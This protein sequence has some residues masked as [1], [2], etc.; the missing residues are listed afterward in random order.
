MRSNRLWVAVV[1][2]ISLLFAGSASAVSVCGKA[3]VPPWSYWKRDANGKKTKE[4][5]GA[6]V[7]TLKA[8]FARLG[9]A[10]EFR[11]E[12]SLARCLRMVESGD[13][14]FAMDAP[15]ESEGTKK[16]AY[17]MRYTTLTPQIFFR[18]DKPVNVRVIADLKNAK[19][20]GLA[21]A[22]YSNYGLKTKDLESATSLDELF[23]KVKE[24]ECDYFV[25]ELEVIAG[26]RI[27]G[28]D[29]LSDADILS[30]PVP[31]V[32]PPTK[33]LVAAKNG[34]AAKLIPRLN[35]AIKEVVT[36]GQA[37]AYWKRYEDKLPFTP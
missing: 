2:V 9:K 37:E 36:S 11:A 29:F 6:S 5:V 31:G 8:V 35:V 24:G 26:Y 32:R 18:T 7:D 23:R 34:S 19:G 14:D 1:F 21:G 22:N 3:D 30:G 12:P 4:L 16:L 33:H 20:C 15:Y 10:V 13:I 17:T 25:E 27:L 28:T